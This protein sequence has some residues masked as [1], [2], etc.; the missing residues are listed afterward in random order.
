[1]DKLTL[2]QRHKNMQAVKSKDSDIELMLRRELGA[3]LMLAS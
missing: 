3:S 2:E 1:M